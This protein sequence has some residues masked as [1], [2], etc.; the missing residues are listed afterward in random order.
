MFDMIRNPYFEGNKAR[1][2]VEGSKEFRKASHNSG[3]VDILC[4]RITY[5]ANQKSVSWFSSVFEI[6]H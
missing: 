1:Y 5:V 6:S 3:A 4:M 2:Y